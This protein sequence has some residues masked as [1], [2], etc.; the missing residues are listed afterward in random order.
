MVSKNVTIED[1]DFDVDKSIIEHIV[2]SQN[3]TISS[4]IGE[5][6]MN[7]IDASSS[8]CH[9][10]IGKNSF[11]IIDKGKGFGTRSEINKY[12][13]TFGLKHKE[14]DAKFG[15]F[16]I[17]R[18]Q[19]M[20]LAHVTWHSGKFKMSTDVKNK[21]LKYELTEDKGDLFDGCRVYG[22]FYKSIEQW[23]LNKVKDEITEKIKYVNGDITF[24][25]VSITKNE[26]VNWDYEDD[27]FKVHWKSSDWCNA[28]SL[29]NMGVH[30]KNF[31][32]SFYGVSGD[33]VTKKELSLNMARNEIKEKDELWTNIKKMLHD[34]AEEL[35]KNKAKTNKALTSDEKHATIMRFVAGQLSINDVWNLNLIKDCRNKFI[36]VSQLFSSGVPLTIPDSVDCR[37]AERVSMLG[38]ATVLHANEVYRWGFESIQEMIRMFNLRVHENDDL[39][40]YTFLKHCDFSVVAK[41]MDETY[42]VF[43]SFDLTDKQKAAKSALSAG[44]RVM[45]DSMCNAIWKVMY[46]KRN[47]F[48]GVSDVA[49]AWTDGSTYVTFGDHMLKHLDFGMKGSI[50][51]ASIMLHEYCHNELDIGSHEHNFE[52]YENYH[53]TAIDSNIIAVTAKAINTQYIASLNRYRIK[54][55]PMLVDLKVR[56]AI[57]AANVMNE[58]VEFINQHMTVVLKMDKKRDKTTELGEFILD[59]IFDTKDY[60]SGNIILRVNL[61]DFSGKYD[62][63]DA[64]HEFLEDH[65]D[66]K[67]L[68]D[69]SLDDIINGIDKYYE[70][71]INKTN[72][73]LSNSGYKFV[74]YNLLVDDFNIELFLKMLCKDPVFKIK[75]YLAYFNTG[76]RLEGDA[77]SRYRSNVY[78]FEN[79][80]VLRP[81][82][83]S[84]PGVLD[85]KEDEFVSMAVGKDYEGRVEKLLA[86]IRLATTQ[87]RDERERKEFIDK[88]FSSRGRIIVGGEPI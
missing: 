63:E 76:L 81:Y 3:G 50:K 82:V 13:K 53:D 21:G 15:R 73:Y 66:M 16:R 22:T 71:F 45:N 36:K 72:E 44:S 59:N 40:N 46:R 83:F 24:N 79:I 39:L 27:D 69:E 29:F 17:G 80:G 34:K 1:I 48:I 2:H 58:Q 62:F 11:E 84:Q 86:D 47:V 65:I 28:V 12:F 10:T 31:S 56:K 70:T 5:L 55:P 68:E 64:I 9:I 60:S 37:K 38:S 75:S 74:N 61:N 35:V 32:S 87:L 41:G 77:M 42:E 52:F 4:A 30:V 20:S 8:L 51:L 26:A 85:V 19:I 78:D 88:Y 25:G 18:G 14:G 6:V 23:D 43:K 57:K 67:E 54:L 7:S 33:V 49:E